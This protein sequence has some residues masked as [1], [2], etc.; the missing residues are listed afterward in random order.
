MKGRPCIWGRCAFCDYIQD[1]CQS[2][3]EC[4]CV[5]SEVLDKVTGKYSALEVINSGSVFELDSKTLNKIKQVCTQKNIK[6]LYFECYYSYKDRLDEIREFF[7]I[8]IIFKCGIE[9]FDEHFRN[10]VLKKGIVF[11]SPQQVAKYF[12]SICLMVGI[13]GQTK[14]SIS[15]DIDILLKH[16]KYGCV[17]V[18]CNNNTPI[19][20][21][22]ELI[23]WFDRKYGDMLRSLDNIDYLYNNTDFGVG[24]L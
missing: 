13:C 24:S 1:N 21:D 9:T 2:E 11:D 10:K 20:A 3:E 6:R 17:N 4:F 18:Y 22:E 23:K 14:E 7:G 5:N 12:D 8:D 15:K 16:F 19:K